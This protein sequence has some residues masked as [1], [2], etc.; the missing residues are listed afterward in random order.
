[1]IQYGGGTAAAQALH[2]A[3]SKVNAQGEAFYALCAQGNTE[4]CTQFTSNIGQGVTA[5]FSSFGPLV[6]GLSS[7]TNPD[8]S[9]LQSFPSGVA[10]AGTPQAVTTPIPL[11]TSDVLAPYKP[12]LEQVLTLVNQIS[13]LNNRVSLLQSLLSK[14]P[15]FN[16]L[17]LLDLVGYLDR[18][19]DIY[20]AD[21]NTLIASLQRCLGATSA[22]VTSVCQSII[23]NQ[24]TNAF[25]YY[26]A[27]GPGNSFF[28]QQNTL[29]LQYTALHQ[30]QNPV[31]MDV[32]YIDELPSF[33]F[34][35]PITG[36][37]A[38]V[39]FVDRPVSDGAGG[40]LFDSFVDI[41]ALEPD[42]PLSTNNVSTKVRANPSASSPFTL[43]EVGAGIGSFPPP[44]VAIIQLPGANFIAVSCTPTFANPCAIDYSVPIGSGEFVQNTQIE[45]LFD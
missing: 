43:W 19:E 5:A 17:P 18:L 30:G 14:E 6:N 32:L 1:M 35:P 39:G 28:A 8:L 22:N 23:T 16:P 12:Q 25:Q 2:E 7:A 34:N 3:F 27:N 10:G 31:S 4:A 40:F 13:T 21:R 26:G 29:A 11:Q 15:K 36:E 20:T 44:D 37:A 41:L 33:G 45:G 42:A 38:F 9:F 24:A